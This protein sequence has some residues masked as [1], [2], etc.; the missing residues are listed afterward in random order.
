MA[1]T[2][3]TCKETMKQHRIMLVDD[4]SLLRSGLVRVL[5]D[6]PDMTVC[7][8]ADTAQK[9]VSIIPECKPD[10]MI[11]DISLKDIDGLRLTKLVRRQHPA[12]RILV[13]SMHDQYLYAGKA[14][15]AGANGYLMKEETT[16]RLIE[17]VRAVLAGRTWLSSEIRDQVLHTVSGPAEKAATCDRLSDRERQIFR[18]LGMGYGSRAIAHKLCISTKTVDTHRARIKVKLG[19]DSAPR[20]ILAAAEWAHREGSVAP[21]L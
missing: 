18:F 1:N 5:C 3:D 11:V 14:L 7:G 17:A 10:L 20:L 4:H 13:L 19:I 2:Q 21:A 15:R 16:E 12:M 9:A 6:E 8:E